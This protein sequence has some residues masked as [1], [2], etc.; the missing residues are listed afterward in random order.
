ME[1]I[2]VDLECP[3]CHSVVE[4]RIRERGYYGHSESRDLIPEGAVISAERKLK[5]GKM[6]YHYRFRGYIPMCSN[7]ACFLYGIT[8]MFR[9]LEEAKNA[10][11]ERARV[12]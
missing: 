8:K 2:L 5:S 3:L 7:R 12:W 9:S 11:I 4:V 10:W 1:S 6:R